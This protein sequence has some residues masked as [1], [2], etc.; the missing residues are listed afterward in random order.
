MGVAEDDVGWGRLMV[1]D[2]ERCVGR[3]MCPGYLQLKCLHVCAC[4]DYPREESVPQ[5]GKL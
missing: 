4:D 3:K 2:L 1:G 5:V